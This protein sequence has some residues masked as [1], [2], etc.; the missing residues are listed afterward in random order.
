MSLLNTTLIAIAGLLLFSTTYLFILNRS[1]ELIISKVI[2]AIIVGLVGTFLTI[3]FSLKENHVQEHTIAA[4]IAHAE[5]MTPLEEIKHD[6]HMFYGGDLHSPRCF[7]N[8]I[9]GQELFDFHF[10]LMTTEIIHSIFKTFQALKHKPDGEMF[11][12]SGYPK[13][14]DSSL[15]RK[16]YTW[17]EYINIFAGDPYLFEALKQFNPIIFKDHFMTVPKDTEIYFTNSAHEKEIGFK[18]EYVS[19]S[20]RIH[21]SS[22]ERNINEW[23]WILNLE[24]KEK[25]EYWISKFIIE[26]EITSNKFRSGHPKMEKYEKWA[27]EILSIIKEKYDY[28]QQLAN[29]MD[30][31][32]HFGKQIQSKKDHITK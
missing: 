9:K 16:F 29:A 23:A 3:L 5:R 31:S 24:E 8:P 12:I 27:N 21:Q 6:Y 14:L 28:N 1:S 32:H 25:E 20:I 4:L 15:Q 13:S 2:P 10:N 26:Q 17:E 18:N 22:G 7:I 19:Y 11:S 30:Y